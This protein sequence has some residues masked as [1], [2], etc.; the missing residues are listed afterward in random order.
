MRSFSR[1]VVEEIGRM[2]ALAADAD[3]F[4]ETRLAELAVRARV[5]VPVVAALAT[6]TAGGAEPR[7]HPLMEAVSELANGDNEAVL[8]SAALRL[9]GIAAA[10]PSAG[11]APAVP[12]T[13]AAPRPTAVPTGIRSTSSVF[14]HGLT[15]FE[16]CAGGGGQAAGLAKAGFRHVGLVER[17]PSACETLRAAFGPDHVVE[18]DVVGYE[19]GDVGP[20]DLLAGGVPCQ[21]FSQA[22]E[23]KGVADDRDLFPEALRLV[24]RLRPRA[25]MLENVPGIFAPDNDMHRFSILAQFEEMGYAT[26]WRKVDATHFGVP[27][28]R[29]RAVLVAFRDRKAMARFSWPEPVHRHGDDAQTVIS[30]LFNQFVSRGWTPTEEFMSGMDRPSPTVTGGSDRK[31]GID[32]GQRKTALVWGEMGFVQTR[33]GN[34][35]PA[36]DHEGP[37]EATNVMLAALQAFPFDWPFRGSKKAVFRQVA[38]AFPAPVAMHLGCAIA[39]ALTGERF[40]PARQHVHEAMRWNHVAHRRYLPEEIARQEAAR[41]PASSPRTVEIPFARLRAASDM[42][43]GAGSPS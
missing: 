30:A 6:R 8:R 24:E 15:A 40:D 7:P 41:A 9:A 25:V 19:P 38:N 1:N 22:G 29:I 26:E 36:E 3:A 2:V 31:Q 12:A 10:K 37:V 35:P 42:S 11:D 23:R 32:F 39:S 13:P 33:I 4:D 34:H 43:N 17:D 18:A 16:I 14:R 20:V 5:L 28:K 21:P 27:Q